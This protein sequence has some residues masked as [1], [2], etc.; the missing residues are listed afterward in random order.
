MIHFECKTN[1]VAEDSPTTGGEG[2]TSGISVSTCQTKC[3]G[4]KHRDS[5]VKASSVPKSS[6]TWA[7]GARGGDHTPGRVTTSQSL[8]SRVETKNARAKGVGC[9]SDTREA[10]LDSGSARGGG[11]GRKGNAVGF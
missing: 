2:G 7:W 5:I 1:T 4:L 10:W 6:N 11:L 9:G 3:S 8:G